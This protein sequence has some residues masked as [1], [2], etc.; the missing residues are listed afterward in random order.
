MPSLHGSIVLKQR[1]KLRDQASIVRRDE[2]V[3]KPSLALPPTRYRAATIDMSNAAASA[4]GALESIDG[5]HAGFPGTQ[6]IPAAQA[7]RSLLALKLFGS[8][9][10]SHVMSSVFDSKLTTYRN[11]SRLNE[12]GIPFITLRR[13]DPKMLQEIRTQ[14]ASAWRRI[15]LESIARTYRTPRILDHTVTLRDYE[16]RSA[17]LPCPPRSP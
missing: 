9:R 7:M 10:H 4:R 8:A 2:G 12:L 5:Q 16:D 13:R 17:R 3:K 14:P 15:E 11:L 6:Q 1:Q